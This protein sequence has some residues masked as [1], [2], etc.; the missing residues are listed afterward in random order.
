M[1]V[2][3]WGGGAGVGVVTGLCT[4]CDLTVLASEEVIFLT[5]GWLLVILDFLLLTSDQ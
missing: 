5:C 3:V 2:S 1:C 4:L